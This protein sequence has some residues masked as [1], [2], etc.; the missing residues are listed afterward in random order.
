[1]FAIE[2]IRI[3]KNYLYKKKKVF[4]NELSEMLNVSEVT[5]RRDLEKLEDEGFLIRTHGGAVLK[6]QKKSADVYN[7]YNS[8]VNVD[9]QYAVLYDEIANIAIHIIENGDIIMLTNGT[10]NYHIAKK[11]DKKK[12]ITVLTN[13]LLISIEASSSSSNKVVLLG[14]NVDFDSKATY[15]ALTALNIQKFFVNKLFIEVDGIDIETGLSVS[16]M[17][18]ANLINSILPNSNEKIILCLGSNFNKTAFY[19]ISSIDMADKIVTNPDIDDFYKKFLFDN[20]I[21]LYTSITA[22]ERGNIE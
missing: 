7:D 21:Q 8:I 3:I 4:V 1:M 20:R 14:G 13:D 9:S 19:N 22:V 6:K 2:R 10:I 15:G 16:N 17:D 12:N 18:K 5:I 11:L